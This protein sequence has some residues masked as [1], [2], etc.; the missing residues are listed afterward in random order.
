VVHTPHDRFAKESLKEIAADF[1]TVETEREVSGEVR[2]IDVVFFPDPARLEALQALGLL[3][4]ILSRP[5]GIEFFRNPVPARE[6]RNC[7]DKGADLRAELE[8]STQQR[9]VKLRSENLPMLWIISPTL[10]DRLQREFS[11]VTR[12]EW[13]DGIYFLPKHDRTAIVVI[14]RLPV[15]LDTLKLRLWGRGS[16]QATAVQE[17][18]ALPEDHP[19]RRSTL[20]HLSILQ[21]NLRM[22]QNKSKDLWEVVMNL[23]PAYEQ[24]E[25]EKIAEGKKLGEQLGEKRGKQL[26]K[27]LGEQLGEKR[28]EKRGK[29]LGKQLGEQLG[30]K[31]GEK[32]GKK[33]GEQLG[34]KRGKKLGATNKSLQIASRLLKKQMSLVEI[35]ELTDLTVEQ[36]QGLQD[37]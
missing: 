32:R 17:L 5:C 11:L 30:E 4:R 13:G 14:H 7:R 37:L 16:V 2:T 12:P 28:G 19:Y 36:I 34:E 18:I 10:S 3:G 31:R 25:A 23:M 8:R 9:R 21:V 20:R 35:A 22:Q 1:G 15:T 24:W 29:K 27:Q 33:L 26:G 6:I